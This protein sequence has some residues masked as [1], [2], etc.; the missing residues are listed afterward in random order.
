MPTVGAA[1]FEGALNKNER[2]K[3]MNLKK[4]KKCGKKST[5]TIKMHRHRLLLC[6]FCLLLVVRAFRPPPSA[7]NA[8]FFNSGDTDVT[9]HWVNPDDGTE[10]LSGRIPPGG[11]QVIGSWEWHQFVARSKEGMLISRMVLAQGEVNLIKALF[12]LFAIKP[13]RVCFNSGP[14]V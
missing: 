11:S 4:R 9:V 6:H 12:A 3:K 14:H 5:T 7:R 13:R 1:E 2:G 10:I 8:T